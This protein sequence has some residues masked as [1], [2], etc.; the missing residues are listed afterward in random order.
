MEPIG[1]ITLAIA[2]MSAGTIAY[3]ETLLMQCLGRV[4]RFRGCQVH[5]VAPS[6]DDDLLV[7]FISQMYQLGI[8]SDPSRRVP[9]RLTEEAGVYPTGDLVLTK[10][11][12]F[13]ASR[14]DSVVIVGTFDH[15]HPGHM[16][17]LTAVAI[18]CKKELHVGLEREVSGQELPE[19][20]ETY[21]TRAGA[22]VQAITWLNP[23]ITVS[24]TPMND[25][26]GPAGS[27]KHVDLFLGSADRIHLREKVNNERRQ[28]GLP[29]LR[30]EFV[31]PIK[32]RSNDPLTSAHIREQIADGRL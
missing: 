12:P 25:G 17:L 19:L 27:L 28:N 1:I 4:P 8:A 2:L 14:V 11:K 30:C 3:D 23:N 21:S 24:I 9:I 10:L 20:I 6:L 15:L 29:R 16:A 22:L 7:S 5:V 13:P 32:I 26:V 31:E 18:L